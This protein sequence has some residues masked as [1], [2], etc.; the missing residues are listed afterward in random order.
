MTTGPNLELRGPVGDQL[1]NDA[2]DVFRLQAALNLILDRDTETRYLDGPIDGIFSI[3]L[4]DALAQYAADKSLPFNNV[5]EPR[6]PL[7]SRLAEDLSRIALPHVPPTTLQF[8]GK[9]LCWVVAG[10]VEQCWSA[11]SGSPPY[12]T[13]NHQEIE[14][15]GPLPEGAW[16]ARQSAHQ[17]IADVPWWNRILGRNVGTIWQLTGRTMGEWPGDTAAWGD[18]RIWLEPEPGTQTF[19]RDGFSIH[20]DSQPGSAGC[21]DLTSNMNDFSERFRNYGADMRLVV[22][23]DQ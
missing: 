1:R 7:L 22:K 2:W 18:V 8:D 13:R 16:I 14:G 19:G 20:G 9:R 15:R 11:I 3:D 6:S 10:S 23:Y 12:T 21:V 4:R 17:R 5:V